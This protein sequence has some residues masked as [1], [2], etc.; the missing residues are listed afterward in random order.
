M[1][2]SL[3]GPRPIVKEEEVKYG[4][5]INKVLSVKPESQGFGKLAEGITWLRKES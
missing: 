5:A 1:E 3:I 2:M 4:N